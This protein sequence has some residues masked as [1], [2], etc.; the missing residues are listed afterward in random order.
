M[1]RPVL[2][3]TFG[4][5]GDLRP[6]V[7]I[8][9]DLQARG[10]RVLL[11]APDFHAATL[12]VSGVPHVG[13][14]STLDGDAV[15]A[16]PDLW[17]HRR[18]IAVLMRSLMPCLR[19]V[20][21]LLVEHAREGGATVI[22]HPLLLP[23]IDVARLRA[24]R[25][26]AIGAWL[27]PANLRSL[28]DPLT[29]GAL[30][31]PRWLPRP[32][33][34]ALWWAID[35]FGV[36]PFILPTLNAW[37]AETGLAAWDRFAPRMQAVA[38]ASI[39]LFAPWFG[40]RRGDWPEPF[41]EGDFVLQAVDASPVTSTALDGFL[42]AGDAPIVFT[43]GTGMRQADRFF[44]EAQQ[45]LRAMG[46]RGVFVTSHAAQLPAALD[47]GIH[48]EP[49]VDF[50]RLLPRAAAIVHHGGIGT[51]A[52]ALRA[53]VP[54]LVTPFGFDQFDNA[55]RVRSLGVGEALPAARIDA[56]RLRRALS[57]LLGSAA[58]RQACRDTARSFDD[59]PG[60]AGIVDRLEG[61]IR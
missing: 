43:A 39:G 58:V 25:L 8:A 20:S 55:A 61:L 16:D 23:A 47:A 57:R 59:A 6:F 21:D 50:A 51:T 15:L 28:E 22:A 11:I 12:A 14:G 27:A 38:D 26:R 53:G 10:H 5:L 46:R 44:A 42:A 2:L 52:E 7:L 40:P 1:T 24:T 33:R 30:K 48:A 56:E 29:I 31:V 9:Q 45:A 37:R 49:F 60:T 19:A 13:Y 41:A 34:R 4:T 35:R 3:A 36:D 18:G 54:Q 32:A 17:H